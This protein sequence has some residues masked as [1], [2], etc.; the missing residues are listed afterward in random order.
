MAKGYSV[1]ELQHN[2]KHRVFKAKLLAMSCEAEVQ[3]FGRNLDRFQAYLEQAGLQ[4][5][6]IH[7]K[8]SL[9][10][11]SSGLL[12]G[13][14]EITRTTLYVELGDTKCALA[15]HWTDNSRVSSLHVV[16]LVELL[17]ESC[18][19]PI[20]SEIDPDNA[21]WWDDIFY[22]AEKMRRD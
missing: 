12:K 4:D 19:T 21:N 1:A 9:E 13:L 16:R 7:A 3:T 8:Y 2:L 11:L 22:C 17:D 20:S 10:P 15:I 6:M 14:E 18:K 5:L